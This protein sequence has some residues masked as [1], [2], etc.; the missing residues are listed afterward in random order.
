MRFGAA[1]VSGLMALCLSLVIIAIAWIVY[2][3]LV[4]LAL[5]A[6]AALCIYGI[7]SFRKKGV[8]ARTAHA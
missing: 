3:P 1:M 6:V 2:R 7:S 5:L 4:G 8:V